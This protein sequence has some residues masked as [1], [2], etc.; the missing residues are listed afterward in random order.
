MFER[1]RILEHDDTPAKLF[2]KT[3]VMV[4]GRGSGEDFSTNIDTSIPAC[5]T[6]SIHS[7]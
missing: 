7:N 1:R 5:Y 4:Q 3:V 2:L 6:E